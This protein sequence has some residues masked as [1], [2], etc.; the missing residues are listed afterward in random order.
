LATCIDPLAEETRRW[1]PYTYAFDNPIRFI[2]PDGMSSEAYNTGKMENESETFAGAADLQAAKV[3]VANAVNNITGAQSPYRT[4]KGQGASF[5]TAKA[6]AK[7]WGKTYNDNSIRHNQE[8]AS[9]IYQ[10]GNR[11]SYSAAA[12]GSGAGV[13]E[14]PAPKGTI[15]AAIIHSHGAYDELYRNNEFSNDASS[16]DLA[17]AREIGLDSYL[18]TPSGTLQNLT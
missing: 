17:H 3:S 18:T 13:E 5:K 12:A 15:P 4:G 10:T 11:Y 6:A 2:D 7:D 8:R 16:G 14:S 9:T 1:S